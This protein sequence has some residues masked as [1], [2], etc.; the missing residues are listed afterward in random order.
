MLPTQ[1][2]IRTLQATT[3]ITQQLIEDQIVRE[4]GIYNQS[5]RIGLS[6]AEEQEE[7]NISEPFELEIMTNVLQSSHE[8][9]SFSRKFQYIWRLKPNTVPRCWGSGE[10]GVFTCTRVGAP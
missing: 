8:K 9:L 4:D 2:R 5:R 3:A 10:D 1:I 7:K 6:M